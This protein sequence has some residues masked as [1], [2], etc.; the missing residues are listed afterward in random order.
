[1]NEQGLRFRIGV[2]VLSALILLAVLIMLFGS[3]PTM[4]RRHHEYTV[5]FHDAPGVAPGT[6]VRRS[7][8][9]IGE[10]R[11]VELDDASGQV[12]V[13]I[14]IEQ[15]HPLYE[16]DQPVL[17]H[18][19][20]SGDTTIDFVPR[21]ATGTG[22]PAPPPRPS[23]E[24]GAVIPA[25]HQVVAQAPAEPPPPAAPT[26]VPPGTVF[27]GMGQADMTTLLNRT[28]EL[29]PSAQE[30]LNQ[31]QRTLQRYDRMAPL[32]E[33]TLR[34][35]RELSRATREALPDLRRTNDEI[36]V[37]IRTWGRLGER[38]D[39]LLQTNQD[40]LVKSI[41]NLNDAIVRV[42]SVF[43]DENQRNLTAMLKNIRA[44]SENLESISRSTDELLRESRNTLKRLNDTVGQTE[45][46]LVN[47]QQATRPMAERSATILRNLD[48]STDRLNRLLGETRE[49]LRAFYQG[50]GTLRRLLTDPALYNNMNDAAC[51]LVRIMPRLDKILKDF[52][53]FAD[54]L[55][56]HPESIGLGGVVNPSSGLKDAPAAGLLRPRH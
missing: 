24:L 5:L 6:P 53:V 34:E 4:F 12:R 44:G 1:M 39:V 2:F 20:L 51:M 17:V 19:L 32:V 25:S 41:D 35:Y 42:A 23:P 52:E 38:L 15:S 16:T 9:R 46:I 26:P 28:S 10:V 49:L 7:G 36:Q 14:V 56:R 47:L 30:S 29:V 18:G 55:A 8:V 37:T 27:R 31:I 43:N 50:D 22:T 54:K 21:H 13:R 3:I 40:K 48:E 45:Q 33:E 11:S